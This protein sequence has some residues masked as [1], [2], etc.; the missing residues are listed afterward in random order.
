MGQEKTQKSKIMKPFFRFLFWLLFLG[1]LAGGGILFFWIRRFDPNQYKPL[2]EAKIFEMT[3]ANAEIVDLSLAWPKGLE[4]DLK[5]LKLRNQPQ[6]TPF[7]AAEQISLRL[8]LLSFLKRRL[9]PL[10]ITVSRPQLILIQRFQGDNNWRIAVPLKVEGESGKPTAVA[11]VALFLS[12]VRLEDGEVVFRNETKFPA[13]EY[14]LKR[15][16][17]EVRQSFPGGKIVMKGD[18]FL[19][20]TT[21]PDL[22]WQLTFHPTQRQLLYEVY[23]LEDLI[24]LKGEALPFQAEPRFQ[25]RLELNELNLMAFYDLLNLPPEKRVLAGVMNG[26]MEYDAFGRAPE[27]IKRSVTAKG[28]FEIR[29]GAFLHFNLVDSLLKR[30]SIIPGFQEALM[31]GVPPS[32]QRLFATQDTPFE[33]LQGEF[34]VQNQE[35]EVKPLVLKDP[36]YLAEAEGRA[37]FYGDLDFRAKLVLLEDMTEYLVGRVNEVAYLINQQGRIVIPFIYRGRWPL[38]R[39]QPDLPGLAQSLVADRG[40]QLLQAGLQALTQLV[41]PQKEE[42]AATSP[43][44][45]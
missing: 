15:I 38:A 27:Q 26:G 29:E 21:K 34:S 9:L 25:G 18:G 36:Y 24:Q 10:E 41:A 11:G 22:E 14:A 12:N 40:E 16:R 5:G 31:A 19:L 20:P 2:L 30:V 39:P 43:S 6:E 8:D 1:L 4:I 3:G 35:I 17:S 42:P 28:I 45:T 37:A 23:F 13:P 32:L 7:F 44:N 33:A